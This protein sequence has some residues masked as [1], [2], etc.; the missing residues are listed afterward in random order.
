MEMNLASPD[1]SDID[2]WDRTLDSIKFQSSR[3][4]NDDVLFLA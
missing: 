1:D 2:F 4:W 3:I